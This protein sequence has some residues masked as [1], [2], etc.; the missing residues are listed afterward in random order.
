MDRDTE[1][2]LRDELID[3]GMLAPYEKDVPR[4]KQCDAIRAIPDMI[5]ALSSVLNVEGPAKLGAT[6]KPFRS[7]DVPYYFSKVR[8]ALAKACGDEGWGD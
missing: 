5:A 4:E 2:R 8:N 7:I 3:M 6:H 1:K